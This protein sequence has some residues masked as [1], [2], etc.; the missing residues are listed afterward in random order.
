MPFHNLNDDEMSSVSNSDLDISFSIPVHENYFMN[1]AKFSDS[2]N[3]NILH[4]N[5]NSIEHKL[6][7]FDEI[8][9]ANLFDFVAFSESKLDCSTSNK[10]GAGYGYQ[11]LRRDRNS[12]GG[13]LLLFVSKD[14]K[15]NYNHNSPDFELIHLQILTA[16]TLINIIYT[17]ITPYKTENEAFFTNLEDYLFLLDPDLQL[18]VIGDLN[19][20]L[21]SLRGADLVKFINENELLNCIDK[22]TRFNKISMVNNDKASNSL[23][24]VC[25]HKSLDNHGISI[26]SDVHGCP[27]SDH[28]FVYIALNVDGQQHENEAIYGRNLCPKNV[29][30]ITSELKQVNF[31]EAFKYYETY[32]QWGWVK[33]KI[34]SVIDKIAP[35]K[36]LKVK[37]RNK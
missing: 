15:I 8:L 2:K 4:L 19:E 5:V 25:L 12:H 10:F 1:L 17:Y 18:L 26:Y 29:E 32:R 21:L 16:E 24:D 22:P 27:F 7:N 13:G 31:N 20:D 33:N 6:I 37:N 35:I 11:V 30:S 36:C 14:L 34:L 23:L 3:L 28:Q 9:T